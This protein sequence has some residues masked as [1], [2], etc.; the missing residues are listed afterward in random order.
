MLLLRFKGGRSESMSMSKTKSKKSP[1]FQQAPS[2]PRIARR[3]KNDVP[4][5]VRAGRE[6]VEDTHAARLRPTFSVHREA[7]SIHTRRPFR[8]KLLILAL[9]L[10]M[11][12]PAR[13][14]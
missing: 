12:V 2:L 14:A 1:V 7:G 5:G 9:A 4:D 3:S 8:M 11:V 13:S 6:A 10:A